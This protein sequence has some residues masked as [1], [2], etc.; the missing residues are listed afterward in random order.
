MLR[1]LRPLPSGGGA[2]CRKWVVGRGTRVGLG[3]AGV[4]MCLSAPWHH[5]HQLQHHKCI[6]QA[7]VA[8]PLPLAWENG[9]AFGVLL[10][11]CTPKFRACCGS[12]V[13]H[14]IERLRPWVW[15]CFCSF[16][17]GSHPH[18]THPHTH[19]HRTALT[20]THASTHA[21]AHART[22]SLVRTHVSDWCVLQSVQS[23]CTVH[24][25]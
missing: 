4:R 18:N 22:H 14:C 5:L 12:T 9:R 7:S 25:T 1:R 2:A 19:T 10:S 8:P 24:R 3:L 17:W 20:H 15:R 11:V 21:H 16:M 13:P 6:T 23:A